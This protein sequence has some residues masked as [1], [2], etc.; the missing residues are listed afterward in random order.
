MTNQ[1]YSNLQVI[2][3]TTLTLV[4]PMYIIGIQTA[5][6]D[7]ELPLGLAVL[8]PGCK[9]KT[10]QTLMMIFSPV[11]IILLKLQHE[12]VQKKRAKLLEMQNKYLV[13]E[14]NKL[15][16]LL[17]KMEEHKK[18]MIK[19]D[20]AFEVAHQIFI[21]LLLVL[22]STSDTRT[23]TGMEALFNQE[24][25]DE[26]LGVSNRTIF[27]IS[28]V[29][30]FFSFLKQYTTAHANTWHWKAKLLVALYGLISLAMR[31]QAMLVYFMPSLGLVHCLRHYQTE[32]IPFSNDNGYGRQ[33]YDFLNEK[34]YYGNAP[35]VD[36]ADIT[37]VNY[38]NPNDPSPPPYSIYTGFT[39]S[40]FF[41]LFVFMWLLQIYV[42]WLYNVQRSNAFQSLSTF[43]QLL[44]SF[45][46]VITPAP[47][48]DWADGQGDEVDHF[49]RMKMNQKEVIG[50]IKINAFFNFLY[51]LPL[52]YLGNYR[53][54]LQYWNRI[55]L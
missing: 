16:S 11:T 32:R 26:Y 3:S 33:K 35:V 27:I 54:N 44:H 18:K 13:S 31:L 17:Q 8:P 29:A 21:N 53:S 40:T 14:F 38:S 28:T 10:I 51:L 9:R 46:S 2:V 39:S 34:L 48:V 19:T 43:N 37:R 50:V 15:S 12:I 49:N 25:E 5:A 42:I 30:S 47:S 20:I 36:W 1:T 24:G 52:A 23:E 45:Q 22:F 4:V 7:P 41:I 6:N 55:N